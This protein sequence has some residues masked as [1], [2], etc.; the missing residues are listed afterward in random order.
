MRIGCELS[1][2]KD[3]RAAF[4]VVS[5][6]KVEFSEGNNA[7]SK[8]HQQS[9]IL[10]LWL[11]LDMFQ[12]YSMSLIPLFRLISV[13][14]CFIISSGCPYGTGVIIIGFAWSLLDQYFKLMVKLS[15]DIDVRYSVLRHAACWTR[16]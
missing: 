7:A 6:S 10:I 9:F 2:R 11:A 5:S 4:L 14:P 16:N 13:R 8:T 15:N 3:A 1:C 12:C